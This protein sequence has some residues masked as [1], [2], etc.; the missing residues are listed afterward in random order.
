MPS[1]QLSPSSTLGF[2]L[3]HSIVSPGTEYI[4]GS[5]G[6]GKIPKI[7]WYQSTEAHVQDIVFC[8]IREGATPKKGGGDFCSF[9]DQKVQAGQPPMWRPLESNAYWRKAGWCHPLDRMQT[10]DMQ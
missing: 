9:K 3:D 4:W 7:R 6:G 10:K 8:L 2:A 1:V 5:G